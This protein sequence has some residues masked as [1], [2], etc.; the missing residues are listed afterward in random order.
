MVGASVTVS[1]GSLREIFVG[2]EWFLVAS[3][4]TQI[5]ICDKMGWGCAYTLRQRQIPGFDV[6]QLWKG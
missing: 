3:V 5:C 6:L 2:I 1:R 4:M